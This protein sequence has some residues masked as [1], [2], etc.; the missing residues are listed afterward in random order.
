MSKKEL[1]GCWEPRRRQLHSRQNGELNRYK[2][3]RAETR[4]VLG[5]R[6]FVECSPERADLNASLSGNN[7]VYRLADARMLRVWKGSD[8]IWV[9]R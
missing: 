2:T 8:A 4:Q 5:W 7:A 9:C 1:N 6:E 3:T